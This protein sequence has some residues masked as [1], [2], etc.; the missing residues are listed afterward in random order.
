MIV[1]ILIVLYENLLLLHGRLYQG[2]YHRLDN[3]AN[4]APSATSIFATEDSKNSFTCAKSCQVNVACRS[5]SFIAQ[6]PPQ[7]LQSRSTTDDCDDLDTVDGA[8]TYKVRN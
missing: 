8:V 6:V 1:L 2:Q 3:C 5:F 4:S 7:C